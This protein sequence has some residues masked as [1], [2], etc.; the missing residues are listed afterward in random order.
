MW[1]RYIMC[2]CLDFISVRY[3][4]KEFVEIYLYTLAHSRIDLLN[5]H[6]VRETVVFTN[7]LQFE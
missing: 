7:M 2:D 4:Q 6:V 1:S 5:L 3:K